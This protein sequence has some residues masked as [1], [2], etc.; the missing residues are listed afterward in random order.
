MSDRDISNY[1]LNQ[2]I[3]THKRCAPGI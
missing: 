1:T 2:I 3:S